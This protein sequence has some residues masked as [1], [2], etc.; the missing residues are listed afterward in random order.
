MRHGF[1]R[2]VNFQLIS[3]TKDT[4]VFSIEANEET[5]KGYPFQFELQLCYTLEE[6]KLTLSYKVINKD[7]VR[8]P[9]SIG[10]HPA[11]ALPK[12][13][14]NYSLKFEYSENLVSFQLENDLLSDETVLY[15]LNKNK[16]PLSY[17]LFEKDALIFK[18][19]K[20]KKITIIENDVPYLLVAFEDFPNLGIWT[21]K[22]AP[23]IC[24]EPWI[25]YSDTVHS[26]GNIL[27]KEAI[28]FVEQN[29]TFECNFSIEIL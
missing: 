6:Q 18:K 28:Q 22:N 2:D 4:A 1:A 10:A 5:L 14:E 9:F 13:F 15:K 25:G 17:S 16:L 21:K 3:D 29:K 23:F 11:F 12:P 7:S 24:L 26:N 20:S 27:D 19:L 8:I